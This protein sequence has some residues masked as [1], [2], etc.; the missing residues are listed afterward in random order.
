MPVKSCKDHLWMSDT[1]L[2]DVLWFLMRPFFSVLPYALVPF[3]VRFPSSL[4]HFWL[5]TYSAFANS[6]PTHFFF[7]L[8]IATTFNCLQT[9]INRCMK[10]WQNKYP[11]KITFKVK[12]AIIQTRFFHTSNE[13]T[14]G[15]LLGMCLIYVYIYIYICI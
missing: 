2:C 5:A 8:L 7:H 1:S 11:H 12:V 13:Q 4:M 6:E 15:F 3:L 9:S 10:D 14:Y